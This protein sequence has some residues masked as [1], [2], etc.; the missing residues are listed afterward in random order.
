LRPKPLPAAAPGDVLLFRM[1]PGSI[2][3][4]LGIA[5]QVGTEAS[6]VHAYSGHGVVENPLSDPWLRRIVARFEF[7]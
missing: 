7:P 1:R 3:K 2:A 6:F 5:G 4:H